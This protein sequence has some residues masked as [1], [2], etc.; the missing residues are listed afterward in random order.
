MY[1][2]NESHTLQ[3]QVII[4][5]TWTFTL[6]LNLPLYIV[7]DVVRRQNGNSCVSLWPEGWMGKTY[8]VTWLVGVFLPLIL[9]MGLYSRVVYS[10]WFK[11]NDGGQITQ[12]QQVSLLPLIGSTGF[13]FCPWNR[14]LNWKPS[15][16]NSPEIKWEHIALVV[17]RQSVLIKDFYILQVGSFTMQYI[18]M[19]HWYLKEIDTKSSQ[20]ANGCKNIRIVYFWS[21]KKKTGK[22]ISACN[23]DVAKNHGHKLYS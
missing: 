19:F 21:K 4:P 14:K 11:R 22:E 7:K 9:M 17:N 5:V 23:N 6:I 15:D 13:F 16:K 3:F 10:L 2:Y 12:Q 18:L 20:N 8:S 1:Q